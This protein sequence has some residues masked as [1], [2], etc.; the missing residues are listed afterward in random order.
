MALDN[1]PATPSP[2]FPVD[3]D[4]APRVLETV[5]GE[6]YRQEAIDGLHAHEEGSVSLTWEHLTTAEKDTLLSFLR[7]HK[8]VQRFSYLAPGQDDP[9]IYI[10]RSWRPTFVSHNVWTL[11]ARFERR[12]DEG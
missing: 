7:D 12:F 4:E 6:S 10:C 5:F 3:F 9:K 1:F 2:S 11:R 8:G